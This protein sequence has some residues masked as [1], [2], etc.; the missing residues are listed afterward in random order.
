MTGL[1]TTVRM[2]H[3]WTDP[4]GAVHAPGDVV[5]LDDDTALR[6]IHASLAVLASGSP[7]PALSFV[8][9]SGTPT[10]GQSPV[11]D[12]ASGL[13]KPAT[14]LSSATFVAQGA[15]QISVKDAAYAAP[16]DG[17]SNAT[18]AIHAARDAAG[19]GGTVYFPPGTYLHGGL[20]ANVAG[21]KWVL[22]PGA[23]LRLANASNADSIQASAAKVYIVG[24]GTIDGNKAS[25]TGGS[26]GVLLNGDNCRLIGPVVTATWGIGVNCQ[27]AAP[28]V[29]G[30]TISENG[31]ASIFAAPSSTAITASAGHISGNIISNTVVGPYGIQVHGNSPAQALRYKISDNDVTLPATTAAGICIE[32]Y[33]LAKES[34]VIGSA[35]VGGSMGISISGSDLAAVSG[36]TV[37]GAASIGIELAASTAGAVS[38][39]T[40]DG[41]GVTVI[42]LTVDNSGSKGHA[43]TGN[44][45]R[46][47]LPSGAGCACQVNGTAPSDLT[48]TGNYLSGYQTLYFANVNGA[49][50]T[51]NTFDGAG[52]AY[53]AINLDTCTNIAVASN[54][55][56][57]YSRSAVF[58]FGGTMAGI[59]VGP[60]VLKGSTPIDLGGNPLGAG[61]RVIRGNVAPAGISAITVGASPFVYTNADQSS[62]LV[63]VLGGTVSA[64]AKNG[65]TIA[66]GTSAIMPVPVWLEPGEA[67]TVTYTA[68]PTMQKDRK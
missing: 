15:Q 55:M 17:V 46:N 40:V 64:V 63:Y 59:V 28:R 6:L 27:R 11:F 51:G 43:I 2:S 12:A 32:V 31:Q 16:S 65:A 8:E 26:G 38:G 3:Y 21:Q 9:L 66:S 5:S 67:A 1:A 7:T 22:A 41:A 13:F 61:S 30:C 14:P 10:D 60:N 29:R 37:D 47:G 34:H 36:N 68:A 39:N 50:V 44:T 20:L 25:Q 33:G 54:V 52:V 49:S 56:D 53:D 57:G 23:T 45:I 58:A 48:F 35:T 19:V 24:E 18:V 42:G 62:E 4:A